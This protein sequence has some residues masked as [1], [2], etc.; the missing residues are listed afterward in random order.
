MSHKTKNSIVLLSLLIIGLVSIYP[1]FFGDYVH[2]HDDLI[3]HRTR[4]ESYYEAVRHFDFFP[5]VFS[6]M[7]NNY[8]YAADLF[9]PSILLLPFALLRMVGLP[10]VQAF[11]AYQVLIS[12]LTAS[13]AYYAY[14]SIKKP[15]RYALLFSCVYTL[16]TYRLID[17]S[18]RFALGE[19]WAFA[20]LPLLALGVY[21]ILYTDH[22]RWMLTAVAMSLL[23]SSHFLSSLIV[24]VLL[25][26]FLL[27][28]YRL[29][30]KP[31]LIAFLKAAVCCL[32]LSVWI[33][34]P[35]IEQTRGLTFNFMN[36]ELSASSLKFTLGDLVTNSLATMS[37]PYTAINPNV[38]VAL[39]TVLVIALL[40]YKNLS[41]VNKQLLLLSVLLFVAST[42]L[43]PWAIF[44]SGFL[45]TIQFSWRLLLP[46]SFFLSL[47][48]ASLAEQ[49]KVA[50]LKKISSLILILFMITLSFN[51]NIFEE[52]LPD[53]SF[54]TTNEN[55]QTFYGTELGHG[56]EYLLTEVNSEEA[57]R[58]PYPIING[59][60]YVSFEHP[61][62]NA[63]NYGEYTIIADQTSELLLPKFF[64]KG[65]EV[66]DNNQPVRYYMKN[67]LVGL[68]LDKG[69]H[70]ITI[71][72][73]KT[74][75]QQLSLFLS[76]IAWFVV[77]FL[78]L[79]NILQVKQHAQ[80][81]GFA[82]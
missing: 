50:T 30:N 18:A 9:Y 4:M 26:L 52:S 10:F 68:Q 48:A 8:G 66:L 72:Y 42:N 61:P 17:Q 12:V 36:T 53:S 45:G 21:T 65:Y 57:L 82:E 3:F 27:Y 5:K 35:V 14:R 60:K 73:V 1:F 64:Y 29:L 16:C 32:A 80:G 79:A 54:K 75:L 51:V 41:S 74:L 37:V 2:H 77:C 59:Y 13:L 31:A 78:G 20:F 43:F 40:S 44:K 62:L 28:N 6:G 47:L 49:F 23:I 7:G 39:L 38:G 46:C 24:C 58:N 55:A 15:R 25:L 34:L 71:R 33:L 76:G 70:V 69:T 22:K 63:Y 11:F 67:G 19:V 56:K 81:K